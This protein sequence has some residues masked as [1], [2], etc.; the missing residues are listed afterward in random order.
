MKKALT[1]V[2]MVISIVIMVLIITVFAPQLK[3]IND[4]WASKQAN[5]E[6]LQNARVLVDQ[7]NRSLSSADKIT[8]VSDPC[9]TNGYIEFE[10]NTGTAY[11]MDI[12]ANNY[13]EFGPVGSPSELA[14]PVSQLKFSCYSKD[15]FT[16]PTTVADDIRFVKAEVIFP[17]PG[18][19]QDKT[20]T[21]STYLRTNAE[22][23]D[24]ISKLSSLEF[25]PLQGMD[26]DLYKIDNNHFLCTYRGADNDGWAVVLT[27][28]TDN[29]II[30]KETPY[31]FDNN[32]TKDPAISKIDNEHYLCAFESTGP[33][34]RATVLAVDPDDWTI[35]SGNQYLY[36]N[37]NG[38]QPALTRIDD[39]HHLCA[40]RGVDDDGWAVILTVDKSDF[41]ISKG[42][43]FEFDDSF[44]RMPALSKI[45]NE[46]YLCAFESNNS[47]GW[48]VVLIVDQTDWTISSGPQF[49]YDTSRGTQVDLLRIDNERHLCA[50]SGPDND[51]LSVVLV[52]DTSDWT[53]SKKQ[54]FAFDPQVGEMPALIEIQPK[55]YLCLY[56]G[57]TSL[58]AK[59]GWAIILRVQNN[60]WKIQQDSEFFEWDTFNGET[61]S[62]AMID[63]EHYLCTYQGPSG[64]GWAA[65]IEL[66]LSLEP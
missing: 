4:S 54:S 47:D 48:A 37:P 1:L 55:E 33:V 66:D 65:I 5:A 53:I 52:V 42:T 29:W 18:P 19:G 16:T 24:R 45:D 26:P 15:N 17:N 27:V 13:I 58:L 10:D 60:T 11:R 63:N 34:G 32:Y 44:C 36:E 61:P 39:E 59:D 40:Y 3:T 28:D 23:R 51:G 22:V 6:V 50:Y 14:G 21:T 20:F 7:V 41:S 43:K 64:D 49:E 2:E 25:D 12:A 31:E 35:S 56:T 8:D 30:S 62:V 46:H 38:R 9:E 57:H